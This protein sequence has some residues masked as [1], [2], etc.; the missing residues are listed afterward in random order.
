MS[1]EAELLNLIKELKAEIDVLKQQL[2]KIQN[3]P[4]EEK[5]ESK[6]NTLDPMVIAMTVVNN[7][8]EMQRSQMQWDTLFRL[9]YAMSS[10]TTRRRRF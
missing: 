8:M 4:K 5:T 6:E 9:I 1:N 7:M 3:E 10:A 2:N